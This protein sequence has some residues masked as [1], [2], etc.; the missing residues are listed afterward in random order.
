MNELI[1]SICLSL[2]GESDCFAEREVRLSMHTYFEQCESRQ[3][4]LT[5]DGLDFFI[6]SRIGAKLPHTKYRV[7][8]NMKCNVVED[9]DV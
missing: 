4:R 2:A 9:R 3:F 7:T 6:S 8:A 1:L 5:D